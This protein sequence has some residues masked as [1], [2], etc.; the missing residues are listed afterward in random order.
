MLA[1]VRLPHCWEFRKKTGK[2]AV[3]VFGKY[4][5]NKACFRLRK[6]TFLRT[7][8]SI[9]S[10]LGL[11][12]CL[13]STGPRASPSASYT[14]SRA[15]RVDI[16]KAFYCICFFAEVYKI[17]SPLVHKAPARSLSFRRNA[18]SYIYSWWCIYPQCK[19]VHLC[20]LIIY[21]SKATQ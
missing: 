15:K 6:A 21:C 12:A 16:S 19:L 18:L 14:Q 5:L 11:G 2:V 1:V 7:N 17:S 20:K 8:G 9:C 3:T 10:S 4:S 13:I